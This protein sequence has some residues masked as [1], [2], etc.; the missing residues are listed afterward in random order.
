MQTRLPCPRN[1]AAERPP[2]SSVRVNWGVIFSFPR[3]GTEE[4]VEGPG[5]D[6]P[7]PGRKPGVTHLHGIFCPPAAEP[8]AQARGDASARYLLPNAGEPRA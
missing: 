2:A 5:G 7:S 4:R 1:G 6:G 3:F 8:R